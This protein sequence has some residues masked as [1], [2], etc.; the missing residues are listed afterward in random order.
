MLL[1]EDIAAVAKASADMKIRSIALPRNAS[2]S[3]LGHVFSRVAPRGKH[4]AFAPREMVEL[5]DVPEPE[6]RD[7]IRVGISTELKRR[8]ILSDIGALLFPHQ[9][10]A[11][12]LPEELFEPRT[13]STPFA[14]LA[15]GPRR[16]FRRASMRPRGHSD[17]PRRLHKASPE[18]PSFGYASF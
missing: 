10:L 4:P 9:D 12:S 16:I 8:P 14:P 11:N 3:F 18:W 5:P 1:D 2:R 15:I 13:A 17:F 6:N 7:V